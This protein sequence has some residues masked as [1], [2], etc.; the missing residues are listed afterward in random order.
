MKLALLKTIELIY[1]ANIYNVSDV[2]YKKTQKIF[3]ILENF[4]FAELQ[5]ILLPYTTEKVPPH[6]ITEISMH[7]TLHPS[8]YSLSGPQLPVHPLWKDILLS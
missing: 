2:L 1:K 8:R 7:A 5:V 4:S 6:T 3:T